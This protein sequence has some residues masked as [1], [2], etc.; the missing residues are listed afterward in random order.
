MNVDKSLC[1]VPKEQRP[2]NEYLALTEAFGFS[3][4]IDND[5][6][7][8]SFKIHLTMLFLSILV[9]N[10]SNSN[11]WS[12]NTVIYSTFGSTIFIFLFHL[13]IY[14]GWKYVYVRLMQATVAYEESGWY[15]G[16][17]WV[18]PPAILVKDRLSG[19]YQVKP[20]LNRIEK[21]LFLYFFLIVVTSCFILFSP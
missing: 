21:V 7:K 3:W 2:I 1:P 4:T 5:Y 19:E 8:V 14:L 18:K 20:T 15:D 6:Y 10:D 9:F 16:Q 13:R 12:P 17:V 11:A